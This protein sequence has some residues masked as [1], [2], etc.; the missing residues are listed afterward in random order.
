MIIVYIIG[1]VLIFYVLFVLIINVPIRK[2]EVGF[3]FVYV[4]E[5]G[6]VREL[7]NDEMKYLETKFHPNDGARP[8]IK[9][10]YKQLTPDNKICGFIRRN[11]VPN[12]IKINKS[13][14]IN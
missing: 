8:Y 3:E 14:E 2:N 13:S 11:R 4:E 10:R 1:V 12:I 9:Y 5:D 6:S 7:S